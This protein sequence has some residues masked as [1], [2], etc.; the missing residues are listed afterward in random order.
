[1]STPETFALGVLAGI[2]TA[3]A[4]VALRTAEDSWRPE[5]VRPAL[6]RCLDCEGACHL[7][8]SGC[9]SRCGSASV[10]IAGAHS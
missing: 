9:C 6:A 1:M 4:T 10:W 3:C 8:R 5:P 2:I 7:T